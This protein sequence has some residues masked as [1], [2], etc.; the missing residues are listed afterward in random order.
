MYTYK[1]A[2][3]NDTKHTHIYKS[4]RI[5]IYKETKKFSQENYIKL[6]TQLCKLFYPETFSRENHIKLK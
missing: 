6:K 2:P 1:Y 5:Y 4:K 3:H